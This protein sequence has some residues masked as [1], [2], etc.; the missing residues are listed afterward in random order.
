MIQKNSDAQ[1]LVKKQSAMYAGADRIHDRNVSM[2]NRMGIRI[3]FDIDLGNLELWINPKAG[4]SLSYKDINFSCRDDF[5]TVFDKITMPNLNPTEFIRCD[6][7]PFHSTLFFKNQTIHILSLIYQPIVIVYFD[8][9]EVVDIKTDKADL[10]IIRAENCFQ[11]SHP[12]RGYVFEF[13]ARLTSG[14]TYR[15]QVCMDEGRTAYARATLMPHSMLILSGTLKEDS[16]VNV[17]EE[18]S[19][20]NSLV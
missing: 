3:E 12:D 18:L 16:L 11:T 9:S 8:A 5:T 2:N 20:I 19:R 4:Q 6:Y 17:V 10:S 14:S 7:D 15:H 13:G 1:L